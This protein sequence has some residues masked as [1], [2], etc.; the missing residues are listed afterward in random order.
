MQFHLVD[1]IPLDDNDDPMIDDESCRPFRSVPTIIEAE[2]SLVP[3]SF[4]VRTLFHVP[5]PRE[6][7]IDG[8]D[9]LQ[10]AL[11][12]GSSYVVV[13]TAFLENLVCVWCVYI[14]CSE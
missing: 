1:D 14:M 7:V 2:K 8:K 10:G 13:V 12:R 6:V 11:K 5:L 4:A 9:L 3:T